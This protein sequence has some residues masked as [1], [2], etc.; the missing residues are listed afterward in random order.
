MI[1]ALHGPKVPLDETADLVALAHSIPCISSAELMNLMN[2]AARESALDSASAVA[3]SWATL[4]YTK[5]KILMN[6]ERRSAVLTPE[7]MHMAACHEDRHAHV[8][9]HTDSA[10]LRPAPGRRR[11]GAQGQS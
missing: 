10:D 6:A 11:S 2:Q 3:G 9:V 5:G 8:A 1:I 7:T 4:D